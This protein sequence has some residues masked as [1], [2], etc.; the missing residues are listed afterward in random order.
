MY[1]VQLIDIRKQTFPVV[2]D[3][4]THPNK[5]PI[6]I[7]TGS[8]PRSTYSIQQIDQQ[9]KETT[10]SILKFTKIP[11][12]DSRKIS[13]CLTDLKTAKK[14]ENGNSPW[15]LRNLGKKKT[16]NHLVNRIRFR[17][18]VSR[19]SKK[20]DDVSIFLGS[21][22]EIHLQR[23]PE[24]E[25]WRCPPTMSHCLFTPRTAKVGTYQYIQELKQLNNELLKINNWRCWNNSVLLMMINPTRRNVAQGDLECRRSS[26]CAPTH[27]QTTTFYWNLTMF[28]L[29]RD[30]GFKF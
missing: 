17:W 28:K 20:Y 6:H 19:E 2:I 22:T 21:Q 13:D 26:R 1:K 25:E 12:L 3:R 23:K 5:Q 29:L 10:A 9:T 7:Q 11:T 4:L 8:D 18:D 16:R 27:H 24:E 30:I 14:V 15:L